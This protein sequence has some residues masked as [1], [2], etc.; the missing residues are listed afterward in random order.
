LEKIKSNEQIE[1]SLKYIILRIERIDEE[2]LHNHLFKLL[3]DLGLS[4]YIRNSSSKHLVQ[5]FK[6]KAVTQSDSVD[7]LQITADN[8][9]LL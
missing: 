7:H 9:I 1:R 3:I 4:Q 5:F 8:L 6:D 2:W